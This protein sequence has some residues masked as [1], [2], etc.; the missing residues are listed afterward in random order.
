MSNLF[1]NF[2]NKSEQVNSKNVFLYGDFLKILLDQEQIFKNKVQENP[3]NE[4][5]LKLKTANEKYKQL[6]ITHYDKNS[7]E[8]DKNF[9]FI[10]IQNNEQNIMKLQSEIISDTDIIKKKWQE[11]G[12]NLEKQIEN[13][14]GQIE[15]LKQKIQEEFKNLQGYEIT[16]IQE[17]FEN[18]KGDKLINEI[19][20]LKEKK[21]K[22]DN[23]QGEIKEKRDKIKE[24]EGEIKEKEAEIKEKEEKEGENKLQGEITKLKEEIKGIEREITKLKEE[25]KGI[26]GE[27]AKLYRGKL[28]EIMELFYKIFE[29]KNVKFKEE[30][31][32][33]SKEIKEGEDEIS[34]LIIKCNKFQYPFFQIPN[35]ASQNNEIIDFKL[36]QIVTI[37]KIIKDKK[38]YYQLFG[39]YINKDDVSD[40]TTLFIP[41][42]NKF[43]IF[44]LKS[45]VLK[46]PIKVYKEKPDIIETRMIYDIAGNLIKRGGTRRR[47]NRTRISRRSVKRMRIKKRG[48]VKRINMKNIK[49][50][51]KRRRSVKRMSK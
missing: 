40:L 34:D 48:S 26:E 18:L 32:N 42:T 45:P 19:N 41:I 20:V 44:F 25:I 22:E 37:E 3:N 51:K 24:K 1:T 2:L 47:V 5:F 11:N 16:K 33:S 31:S 35:N 17:E 12:T 15:K 13:L 9:V 4:L 36:F 27:I 6:R 23:L 30:T 38:E 46:T 7:Q 29:E 10:N 28:K 14:E 43:N 50:L 8:T 39:R 21:I 49:N